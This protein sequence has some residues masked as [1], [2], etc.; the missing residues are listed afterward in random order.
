[1]EKKKIA[2]IGVKYF[3]SKGGTSRV[4][5]NIVQELKDH[6]EFTVYCYQDPAAKNH[7]PG[8][9]VVEYQEL[10]FGSIGVFFFFVRCMLHAMIWGN[11]DLVHVHKTD[12]AIL[13]PM[14]S[15]KFKCIA[16]SH[17]APYLRDKWTRFEKKYFKWM[18]K[19]FM[20]SDAT[21][22]AI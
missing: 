17:E 20:K 15:K 1:M 5:E 8:V 14:L 22:T 9:K 10:P 16:T 18:E 12:A 3:P 6:F 7:I 19:L 11:Y 4:A 2:V 13:L 21:L